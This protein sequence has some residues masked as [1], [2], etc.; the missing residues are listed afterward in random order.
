MNYEQ[1]KKYIDLLYK[2][3]GSTLQRQLEIVENIS[4]RGFLKDLLRVV[5]LGAATATCC[6][7]PDE[8]NGVLPDIGDSDRSNLSP[9]EADFLGNQVI[10]NIANKGSMLDDYDVLAY[11]NDVGDDLASYSSLAGQNFNFYLVRDK[12]INAFALPGGYICLYN[13]LIYTTRSE[14]ELTSVMAHEI[15]HVVQHHIFRNISGYKRN[16]WVSLAGILSGALLATI[17]PAAGALTMQGTQGLAAQNMLSNSRDFEREADRVGQR[18]MYN[19]GFDPH[20]MPEFFKR[21]KETTKFNDNEAFEFLRTHPVTTERIGE[22]ENRAN[23]LQTKM[24]PDS[25]SFLLSREKCRVRQLDITDAIRFYE[26]SFK[27]K[28]YSRIEAAYYGLSFVRFL[29]GKFKDSTNLLSNITESSFKNHPGIISLNAANQVGLYNFTQA[30]K[31]YD[32][33][34]SNYPS[35]KS[36]WIGQVDLLIKSKKYKEAANKL[37]DLSQRFSSD[38]DVWIRITSIYSDACLNNE[39]K[40]HYALG[41]KVYL[42]GDYR[43]AITQYQIALKQNKNYDV[44]LND[45]IEMHLMI[46]SEMWKKQVEYGGA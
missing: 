5:C 21:L 23:H 46:A 29:D 13:G 28:K 30:Y 8:F 33:G 35:Y 41:N 34:L 38:V 24:R 40:Y 27:S 7:I 43:A 3:K 14:A 44:K 22:A 16:Q 2:S 31:L 32:D 18:I 17:N 19:A 11:L 9:R 20:A 4:R 1:L 26:A 39:Q 10:H 37:E 15:G 12:V 6:A 42:D 25:V 45:V 36:L